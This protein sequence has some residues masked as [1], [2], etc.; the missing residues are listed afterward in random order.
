MR[1]IVKM[2]LVQVFR[3][4]LDLQQRPDE[5][6]AKENTEKKGKHA[7]KGEDRQGQRLVRVDGLIGNATRDTGQDHVPMTRGPLSVPWNQERCVASDLLWFIGRWPDLRG[8]DVEYGVLRCI[9]VLEWKGHVLLG[10]AVLFSLHQHTVLRID[11]VDHRRRELEMGQSL[12][13]L[14]QDRVSLIVAWSPVEGRRR[15]AS[16]ESFSGFERWSGFF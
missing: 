4:V 3:D 11:E 8:A 15:D 13:D 7:G 5:P 1:A 14:S 2:A 9:V 10:I 6:P 12:V 16:F